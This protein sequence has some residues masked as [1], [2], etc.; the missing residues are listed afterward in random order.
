IAEAAKV[1]LVARDGLL[2]VALLDRVP[3]RAQQD[4]P[5]FFRFLIQERRRDQRRRQRR[6]GFVAGFGLPVLGLI[7]FSRRRSTLHARHWGQMAR[8]DRGGLCSGPLPPP[9]RGSTGCIRWWSVGLR[10]CPGPY[11][12]LPGIAERRGWRLGGGWKRNGI[13]IGLGKIPG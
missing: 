1:L 12:G 2:E 9:V 6:D 3:R 11:T 8:W 7:G 5:V 10:C 13:G 4:C